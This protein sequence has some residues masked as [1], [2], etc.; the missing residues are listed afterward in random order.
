MDNKGEEKEVKPRELTPPRPDQ[1]PFPCTE[2]IVPKLKAWLIQK[3]STSSFN[4]SSAP[5]AT[6]SGL[7]MMI[8]IDPEAYPVAVH[9]HIPIPHH[10]QE[11]VKAELDRDCELGIIEKASVGVPKRWQSRM[12]VRVSPRGGGWGTPP[13]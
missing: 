4:T 1:I 10:W 12:V 2:E 11:T 3:F 6:M 13:I 7:P 9:K 5:L 8:H